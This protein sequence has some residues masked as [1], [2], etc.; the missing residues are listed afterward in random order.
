[1]NREE[2]AKRLREI[3]CA[4]PP[5]IEYDWDDTGDDIKAAC[6]A[7]ADFVLANF[8]EN[9]EVERLAADMRAKFPFLSGRCTTVLA[10]WI[11]ALHERRKP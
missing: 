3:Y 8:E 7:T 2:L 1:M 11:L 5:A 10:E 4:V 6:L 9:T